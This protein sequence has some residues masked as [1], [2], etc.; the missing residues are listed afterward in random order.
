M[1]PLRGAV[2]GAGYFSRFHYDAWS[3]M[4]DVE[5]VACCDLQEA[6]ARAAAAEHG[7][8]A[9]Y[10]DLRA[11][12][13]AHE[14]D[15]VDV[16]TRPDSHREICGEVAA[17]GLPAICQKPLAPSAEECAQIVDA[18]E[19]AG[20]RLMVHDNFRFQ[21]WY[22]E[23][24]VLMGRGAIGSRL[25]TISF[26]NR[27]G[28]G[29]GDDAY[30]ARQPYFQQMPRFLLFEAG[31]HTIDTFRYLGGEI[32]RVWCRL[33]RLNPV[34]AG[35]DAA[36]AVFDFEGGAVGVYDANRYNEST[37]E[38]PRYTFG[39]LL[40]E[41]DGGTVRLH[42][43]GRLSLQP[44]GEPERD[45]PYERSRRGFAGDCVLAT[46]RHFVDALRGGAP[47]ETEGR[48]YLRSIAVQEAAYRSAASGRAESPG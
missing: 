4:E 21:P 41:G 13:D 9:A 48:R 7:V 26:R 28:D 43:D 34:I 14:V 20:V 1:R 2:V 17:R 30:L 16:V 29:W 11:M 8:P 36:L 19:A 3:R 42:D 35:E 6:K 32:E 22:R 45:H 5:I 31:I 25:H 15:F 46:Q 38:D 39:E 33:R 12:L 44:L 10:G 23:I 27:A 37:A 24:K 47:F 40:V 18:A